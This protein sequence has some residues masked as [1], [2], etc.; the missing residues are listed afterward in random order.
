MEGFRKS[1]L[2]EFTDIYVFNLRGNARTSGELR[3]K[4]KDNVFGE[5]TRTP[6]A[7]TVLIKKPSKPAASTIHYCDIGDYLTREQKL[8]IVRDMQSVE[9]TPWTDIAPNERGD[10]INQRGGKF[11]TFFALGDKSKDGGDKKI[12]FFG[13][14]YSMGLKTG[15]DAWATSYCRDQLI[16]QMSCMIDYYHNIIYA[17][18]CLIKETNPNFDEVLAKD[19]TQISWTRS[20]LADCK[21]GKRFVGNVEDSVMFG[22]YRPFCKK[23]VFCHPMFNDLYTPARKLFP[24][25]NCTNLIICTTGLGIT[26]DFTANVTD[27][28]PDIHFMDTGQ[29]FPLYYYEPATSQ[30][31]LAS[32]GEEVVDG[33]VRRD[34]ITDA[35]LSECQKRY[36][37]E[38]TKEDIFFYVYGALH[39]PKY[40]EEYANELKKELAR[41]PLPARAETFLAISGI[42]RNLADIHVNYETGRSTI[43]DR[44]GRKHNEL[45]SYPLDI[46]FKAAEG[47]PDEVLYR[48]GDRKMKLG[49]YEEKQEDGT[50]RKRFDGT[51]KF[52]DR[53]TFAGIPQEAFQYVVNGRSPLEWLV[54][55][56]YV[57]TDKASGIVDDPNL[58]SE[59]PKY[60]FKLV[61]RLASVA[62]E[63]VKLTATLPD[64]E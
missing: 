40:R 58:W 10:W 37:A 26:K 18:A 64:L 27:L 5:G 38:I 47:V 1:L 59:D 28:L 4:E 15:R 63:T 16:E 2:E 30:G 61:G 35:M 21:R 13:A 43:R 3:R 54:E 52:N 6:V 29:C 24:S 22:S 48:V 42:G 44:K 51:L 34:A 53:I 33:Y 49:T 60:V 7:I 31:L 45:E 57:R 14:N 56:Y 32:E 50:K 8:G 62:V 20:L 19:E 23:A 9:G 41:L 11:D 36:G 12:T 17:R 46:K 25:I 55:R 39:S